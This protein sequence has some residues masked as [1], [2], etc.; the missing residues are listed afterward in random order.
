M[1]AI[2]VVEKLTGTARVLRAGTWE[3]LR[4]DAPLHEHDTLATEANSTLSIRFADNSL[5]NLGPSSRVEVRDFAFESAEPPSF[6]L[7]M[8]EGVVRSVSGKIVEHDPQ[9]FHLSSPLG[10][11]GIRGTETMHQ[12]NDRYEVHAVVSLGAGHTV[13]I[14]TVDGRFAI[15]SSE[16]KGVIITQGDTS[17][18]ETLEFTPGMLEEYFSKLLSDARHSDGGEGFPPE[19]TAG[20]LAT[21]GGID[22]TKLSSFALTDQTAALVAEML[23]LDQDHVQLLIDPVPDDGVNGGGG[24]IG[25]L[26]GTFVG[27]TGNDMLVAT[28]GNNLLRGMQGDD[29]LISGSGADTLYGGHGSFDQL[30]KYSTMTEGNFF[31][32]DGSNDPTGLEPLDEM[33]AAVCDDDIIQINADMTGG[34]IYGDARILDLCTAGADTI[35]ITGNMSGGVIYGD[36]QTL[37]NTVC[38]NDM[39]YVNG[40]MSGGTIYSDAAASD[41]IGGDDLIALGGM[42]GGMID[43]GRGNDTVT[44]GVFS[45]GA[46]YFGDI[47]SDSK[48]LNVGTF[49]EGADITFSGASKSN[50]LI[51]TG[52]NTNVSITD[53]ELRFNPGGSSNRITP[54]DITL[55]NTFSG[56]TGTTV[57]DA[58]NRSA[59]VTLFGGSGVNILTG[60][61]G[62]DQ[63]LVNELTTGSTLDGRGGSDV[64]SVEVMYGGTV[65]LDNQDQLGLSV[66]TGGTVNLNGAEYMIYNVSGGTVNYSGGPVSAIT[67]LSDT[68]VLQGGETADSIS[69]TTMSGG[70]VNGGA[71]ADSITIDTM[72]AGLLNGGAGSDQIHIADLAGGRVLLTDNDADTLTLDRVSGNCAIVLDAHD[73]ITLTYGSGASGSLELHGAAHT[74]TDI[75][76]LSLFCTS[77]NDSI[78][79][80]R[81]AGTIYLD[82]DDASP[83]NVSA[84][85]TLRLDTFDA[86]NIYGDDTH[87]NINTNAADTFSITT[88][89]AGT[90]HCD[91]STLNAGDSGSND[92]VDIGILN[93]GTIYGDAYTNNGTGGMDAFTIGA[94]T[95]GSVYGD[96]CDLPAATSVGGND[97]I[98]ITGDMTG[99]AVYGDGYFLSGGIGC[100][101]GNDTIAV[102]GAIDGGSLLGDAYSLSVAAVGGNDVINAGTLSS[103]TI[104]G[105]GQYLYNDARGGDDIITITDMSG[106]TVYGDADLIA[107]ITC[108]AGNDT[109]NITGLMSGGSIYGDGT[110]GYGSYTGGQ[111]SITVNTLKGGTIGGGAGN[112]SITINSVLAGGSIFLYGGNGDDTFAFGNSVI[113]GNVAVTMQSF[114]NTSAYGTDVLDISSFGGSYSY[115]GNTITCTA[116]GNTLTISI[117]NITDLAA[118]FT[119]NP[120]QIIV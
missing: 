60:G 44:I 86:G 43:T 20:L 21:L 29:T 31:Y 23:D 61:S 80:G 110:D 58:S 42:S 84:S 82:Q 7:H 63:I 28:A 90:L 25:W 55:F 59:D 53:S 104:F 39:I 109:I 117:D 52:D 70:T 13:I 99:G 75:G 98:H 37:S 76:Q 105:D 89:N 64:I 107:A 18:L 45:G 4:A 115:S 9:A 38:G 114:G 71:G 113:D 47:P 116:G 27:T 32:G 14:K 51:F 36:G 79:I 68:G 1:N 100:T 85:D 2:A 33:S 22:L 57:L 93:G 81:A 15:I 112:D 69:V 106:G 49:G 91:N 8:L 101:G 12:I 102:T 5:V 78:V 24:G 10:T 40:I 88:M 35:T 120:G 56:G 77:G 48:T 54:V 103:G 41:S 50:S 118:Y 62:N 97:N 96:A 87:N 11:V 108:T 66:M 83:S 30:F 119:A 3:D 65:N 73:S 92:L 111:N 26:G 72:S 95:N 34:E 16:L 6:S 67:S 19:L 94:M 46:I 17:P 74:L